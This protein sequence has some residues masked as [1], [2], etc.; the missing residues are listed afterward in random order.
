MAVADCSVVRGSGEDK[1][2]E[3]S[4]GDSGEGGD[5]RGTARYFSGVLRYLSAT[6]R[7][8]NQHCRRETL[9]PKPI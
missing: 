9:C 4:G 7:P 8:D 2:A 6:T 5:P 1:G 3:R